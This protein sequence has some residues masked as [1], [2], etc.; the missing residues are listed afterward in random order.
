MKSNLL[1]LLEISFGPKI[2][3]YMND[4]DV[5][6]IMKNDDGSLFIDTLSQGM[7]FK[8][9]MEADKAL[10]IVYLVANHS[11][12]EATLENPIISAELPGSGFRFEGNI[13]PN[14]ATAT[15]NIRKYSILDLTLDDYV[16]DNIMRK[17]QAEL[18]KKAVKD[19]KNIL[20]VGG[21]GSGKTTLCNAILNEM[22][23]YNQRIVIIQDTKELRCT[24]KNKLFLN[25]SEYVTIRKLLKSTLRRTPTRIVIGEVRDG[26]ALNVLIAWNTGHPGG[27]CTL[28]AD[29]AMKGI[30][31][32]ESYVMEVSASPQR[33]KIGDTINIIIDLQK[34][35][36]GRKVKGIIELKG[37]DNKKEEYIYEYLN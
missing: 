22:S 26:A 5:I 10:N 23:Q 1:D 13:P 20:V 16:K 21:T 19:R 33:E 6:E 7:I 29:S 14:S 24:C 15:F 4:E 8:G 36:L 2:M 32:F 35:G 30:R 37:Y 31:Q 17:S 34:E 25:T 18:I 3:E 11:G 9:Y 12:Q 28:H 27:L